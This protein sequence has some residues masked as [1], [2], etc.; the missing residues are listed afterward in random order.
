MQFRKKPVVIDAFCWMGDAAECNEP[1]WLIAAV[2]RHEIHF[3]G[4]GKL[5]I[6]TLEGIMA[7]DVGD[8]I[9]RDENGKISPCKPDV[10]V[11]TYEPV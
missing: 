10:F 1:D 7:A 4:A 5:Y 3:D 6:E 8:Y 9:V 2:G 11:Q